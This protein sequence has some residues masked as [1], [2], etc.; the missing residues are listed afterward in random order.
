MN[1]VCLPMCS[2]VLTEFVEEVSFQHHSEFFYQ[3]VREYLA[4]CLPK[5]SAFGLPMMHLHRFGALTKNT[6]KTIRTN[7]SKLQFLT[8][9]LLVN[10]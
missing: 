6:G 3:F 1:C 10:E 7:V 9:S 8:L 5:L 4:F 2:M